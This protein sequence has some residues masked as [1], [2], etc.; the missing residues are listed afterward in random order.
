VH[1]GVLSSQQKLITGLCFVICGVFNIPSVTVWTTVKH[2]WER[3][4]KKL[5]LTCFIFPV[6]AEGITKNHKETPV[7]MFG[8]LAEI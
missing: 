5:V 1:P 3:M 8:V 2:E 4:W 7:G 6:F